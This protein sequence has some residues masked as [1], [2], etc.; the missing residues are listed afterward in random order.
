MGLHGGKNHYKEVLLNLLRRNDA[1]EDREFNI[2][3]IIDE[4]Q[5]IDIIKIMKRL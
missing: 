3:T 4:R 1:V 5:A 2:H